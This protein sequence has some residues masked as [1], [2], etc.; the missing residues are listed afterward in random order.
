M[1][2]D[3]RSWLPETVQNCQTLDGSPVA[4]RAQSESSY[5]FH[6]QPFVVLNTP[7]RS[8]RF[9]LAYSVELA[10]SQL[11]SFSYLLDEPS[12]FV[13]PSIFVRTRPI[14][15]TFKV[16]FEFGISACHGVVTESAVSGR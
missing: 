13:F 14:L 15:D 6:K 7:R 11:T 16:E 5:F 4:P 8:G 2:D 9:P 1:K 3:G 12:D 10:L